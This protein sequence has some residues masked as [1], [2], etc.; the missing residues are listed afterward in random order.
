MP[1]EA[2]GAQHLD[3]PSLWQLAELAS[4]ATHGLLRLKK[5]KI[6]VMPM[7]PQLHPSKPVLRTGRA[8]Q[9]GLPG[10]CLAHNVSHDR[11]GGRFGLL[12]LDWLGMILKNTTT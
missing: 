4:G 1:S 11:A 3:C 9:V 5:S 2:I 10:P 6:V 7:V 12:G 8:T